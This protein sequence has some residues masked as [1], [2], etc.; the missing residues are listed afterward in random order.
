MNKT[1]TKA[2]EGSIRKWEKIVAGTGVD[3]AHRNCP[4]CKKFDVDGHCTGCPIKEE[5][6]MPGCAGTPWEEWH[7][8]QYTKHDDKPSRVWCLTCSRLAKKEL[9]FLKKLLK[10]GTK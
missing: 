8:H 9:A 7:W 1:Q 3:A 2:L 10:K 6:N 4:C 5:T